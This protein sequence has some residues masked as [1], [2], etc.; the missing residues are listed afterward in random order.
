MALF[1][2]IS[3]G[4]GG[5]GDVSG[6]GW[7]RIVAVQEPS[8]GLRA[9]IVLHSLA[10]GPA[11]GGIRRRR[12][13]S[14]DAAL[15]D[16]RMLAEAMSLKCALAEL[17]AGGGKTVILDHEG[18]DRPRAYE[19]LG[20]AIEELGGRY[21][22]GPDVGTG[23]AELDALRRATSHVNPAQNDAGRSTAAGVLAG[24]RG[25]S[26]V[27]FGDET[28]GGRRYVIQ[29]L[30]A[31]GGALAAALVAAGGEV[32]GWDPDLHAR[33]RAA[34]VGVR[35]LEDGAAALREPCEVFMPC[36]LGGVL[37]AQ[38]CA[39]APWRAVCGS[40]NNQLDAATGAR[41][42]QTLHERGIAWAP[43]FVVSAGAVIEGVETVLGE[44]EGARARVV[45]KIEATAERCA[46]ILEAARAEN[47][48]PRQV[49][50]ARAWAAV[51][52]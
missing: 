31:V 19:A 5:A 6:A 44:G 34:A 36:A 49:A 2:D 10:R 8:C 50:L 14:E 33:E 15:D 11:F 38:T 42:E 32:A 26:Q 39:A 43:D 20:R 27:V 22:C 28:L 48:P 35:L 1:V 47:R 52:G 7:A 17:D 9:V 29:G 45:E 12:Y 46:A 37:D 40:A 51:A 21:V 16:A 30:G 18:L 25:L 24:L 13:A 23:S 3:G 4:A 41:A